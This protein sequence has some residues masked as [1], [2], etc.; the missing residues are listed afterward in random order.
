M[1]HSIIFA[2]LS[3]L[4]RGGLICAIVFGAASC[5]I[6]L[7]ALLKKG[8]VQISPQPLA[9]QLVEELHEQF[10]SKKSFEEHILG[11]TARHSQLFKK[12]EESEEKSQALI[13]KKISEVNED[14]RRTMDRLDAKFDQL[15]KDMRDMPGKIVVDV[16]NAQKIGRKHD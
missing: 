5:V 2:E 11:N 14:R 7:I 4:E 1:M 10:A 8:E 9:I 13:E 6:A 15:H 16:L 3:G 12:I